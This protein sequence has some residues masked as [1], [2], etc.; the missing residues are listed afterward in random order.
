MRIR[1]LLLACL[2]TLAVAGSIDLGNTA[3]TVNFNPAN[4]LPTI[5]LGSNNC[6]GG[7]CT[8][9]GTAS[10][11]SLTITWAFQQVDQ[12]VSPYSYDYNG[13]TGTIYTN[14][15]P[16]TMFSLSDGTGDIASGTFVLNS[17]A[18]DGTQ[19][20]DGNDGV[21]LYGVA[22]L[23]SLTLSG[24]NSSA[25]LS[26]F[27]LPGSIPPNVNLDFVID[28]GNCTHGGRSTVC[29]QPVGNITD[30]TAQTLDVQ[31]TPENA[32]PEPATFGLLGAGLAA[33]GI[34]RR[35]R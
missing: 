34:A 2:P 26:A 35:K 14:G 19:Q 7:V 24:A 12:S 27:S 29:V 3:N 4:F 30:P 25:F 23:S 32:T 11:N 17:L 15:T 13:S 31:V 5:T 6:V 18:D 33:F 1:H 28:V 10:V 21:D 9:T 16:E 20:K 22:T 8:L